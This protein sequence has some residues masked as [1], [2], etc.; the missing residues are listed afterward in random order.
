MR[1]NLA[2]LLVISLL[3]LPAQAKVM[4]IEDR[5]PSRDTGTTLQQVGLDGSA[6]DNSVDPCVDFYQ[7]ACGS[8]NK[9]TQIPADEASWYRSFDEIQKRNEAELK[10]ILESA[11][12]EPGDDPLRQRLGQFYG[13][14]MAGLAETSKDSAGL[15]EILAKIDAAADKKALAEVLGELQSKDIHPFFVA[16]ADP[17]FADATRVLLWVDQG[18]LGL[19]DRDDYL[20]DDEASKKLRQT[21]AQHMERMLLLSGFAAPQAKE[22][23]A[24]VF[25]LETTLAKASKTRVE[26]REP[27]ALYNPMTEKEFFAQS[28]AFPWQ[29]VFAALGASDQAKLS[30]TAPAFAQELSAVWLQRPLP[31]LKHY[32]RW[33]VLRKLAPQLGKPWQQEAFAL[34]HAITGQPEIKAPWRRCLDTTDQVL[35]EILAQPY[36]ARNFPPQAQSEA[37]R[38]VRTIAQAF[39]GNLESLTWMDA[40]TKKK[41][42]QKA[43][44]MAYLIGRPKA[45]RTYAWVPGPDHLRNLLQGLQT[46]VSRQFKRLGKPVDREQWLMTP[47]T[48]NAY[49]DPSKNHMV[50]PAGILQPPFFNAKAN[51]PVNLGAIGMVIGHEL[52]HGFDDE[53]SQFDALGNFRQWWQP[54]TRTAFEA[55]TACVAQQYDGYEVQKGLHLNG[56]LTLGENIADLGGVKLAFAAY[57]KLRLG[58]AQRIVAE[59]FNEDQQFFLA[60]AQAWCGAMRPEAERQQVQTNPHSTAR[61]RVNGPLAD[62]PEFAAAFQC[63]VGSPMVPVHACSVW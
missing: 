62:L 12:K 50:F 19:P 16:S 15:R 4:R 43:E 20:R 11:A 29:T 31:E 3:A 51:L 2:F 22:A 28:P 8:W 21:Y 58:A 47:P 32:L 56:Q 30:V 7:F 39:V 54:A 49:Y 57:R 48:V 18:G 52:T 37:E 9:T 38:M 14:C 1:R 40:E 60:H 10:T 44:Q 61:F 55:K 26:R 27:K 42:A 17:D 41:A 23:A 53:G 5:T 24:Q 63:K 36:V 25:A 6:M 46:E 59:G 35:G 33:H 45:W 13:R 34:E